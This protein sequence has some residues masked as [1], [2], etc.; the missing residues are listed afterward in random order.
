[1]QPPVECLRRIATVRVPGRTRAIPV[2]ARWRSP[3]EGRALGSGHTAERDPDGRLA[4]RWGPRL[5][6][7][8][9]SRS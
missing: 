3:R 9:R 8:N 7:G 4:P 5:A 6:T 1:M 2:A